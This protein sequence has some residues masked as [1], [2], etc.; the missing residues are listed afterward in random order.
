MLK[1][2]NG[3]LKGN[4]PKAEIGTVFQISILVSYRDLSLNCFILL[5]SLLLRKVRNN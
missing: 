3:H 4:R 2:R 1:E 5:T